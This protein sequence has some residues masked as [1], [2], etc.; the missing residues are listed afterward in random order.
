MILTSQLKSFFSLISREMS[1]STYTIY[2]INGWVLVSLFHKSRL[3][4][5]KRYE[6]MLLS[7]ET[8]T[9]LY[10]F[11]YQPVSFQQ[12]DYK[13]TRF[14]ERFVIGL[15]KSRTLIQSRIFARLIFETSRNIQDLVD[16]PNS[17]VKVSLF[18]QHCYK[19][20]LLKIGKK[21]KEKLL[22]GVS[23]LGLISMPQKRGLNQPETP[24]K[25]IM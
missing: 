21:R 4:F 13:S 18:A 22:F 16:F 20:Y 15:E 6:I 12:I 11:L 1:A 2:G 7:F 19:N 24:Q 9:T 17:V 8:N 25:C 5:V 3:N 14:K 23:A 10:R